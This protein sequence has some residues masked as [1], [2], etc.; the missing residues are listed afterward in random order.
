MGRPDRTCT[1]S[2]WK[3]S[4]HGWNGRGS[5]QTG[6]GG[7]TRAVGTRRR[8]DDF[9]YCMKYFGGTVVKDFFVVV[10][11]TFCRRPLPVFGVL[12]F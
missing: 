2:T 9:R 11:D 10:V 3:T 7:C 1:F 8:R 5:R 4:G 6:R 12:L